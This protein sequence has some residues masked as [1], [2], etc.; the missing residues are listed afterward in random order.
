ML[1]NHVS[2]NFEPDGTKN[3]DSNEYITTL[4]SVVSLH[5]ILSNLALRS[6]IGGS[7]NRQ[8]EGMDKDCAKSGYRLGVCAMQL[9]VC[10]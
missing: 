1:I 9:H 2:H 6:Y 10:A 3:L 8:V 4:S 7:V 5:C